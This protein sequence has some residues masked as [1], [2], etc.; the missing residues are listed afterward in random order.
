MSSKTSSEVVRSLWQSHIPNI[1][2]TETGFFEGFGLALLDQAFRITADKIKKDRFEVLDEKNVGKYAMGV[3]R[4]LRQRRPIKKTGDRWCIGCEVWM[5]AD[6]EISDKDKERFKSQLEQS[7]ECLLF[8]GATTTGGYRK[9]WVN[10]RSI[11]AHIF[12]YFSEI[13]YLPAANALGGVNGLQVAHSCLNRFCCNA[14]HLRLT[15]KGINLAE[16]LYGFIGRLRDAVSRDYGST[17]SSVLTEHTSG[18]PNAFPEEDKGNSLADASVAQRDIN[19]ELNSN[20]TFTVPT[21]AYQETVQFIK[22]FLRR[23][24]RNHPGGVTGDDDITI[25]PSE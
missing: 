11:G 3:I 12:A 4:E 16:R 19:R 7:G 1:S 5:E 2:L 17:Y 15:T 14:R 20:P 22:T 9:F 21:P 18:S 23:K 24:R 10:G 13:G 8:K 6:Y 25:V